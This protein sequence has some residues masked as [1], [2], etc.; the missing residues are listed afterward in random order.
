M[1]DPEHLFQ[2]PGDEVG[3]LAGPVRRQA[4]TW[5]GGGIRFTTR[6]GGLPSEGRE[7]RQLRGAQGG[8]GVLRTAA[9][10]LGVDPPGG[11]GGEPDVRRVRGGRT[12]DGYRQVEDR[13]G[14]QVAQ[15]IG[16]VGGETVPPGRDRRVHVELECRHARQS[17]TEPPSP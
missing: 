16:Q 4:D 11:D 5:A 10:D 3:Q 15:E 6:V 13:A 14:D 1:S 17:T 7:L 2:G 12:E 9:G 8:G